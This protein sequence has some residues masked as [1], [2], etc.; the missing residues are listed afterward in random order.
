MTDAPE[1]DSKQDHTSILHRTAVGAGWTIAWRMC[2]R[3]L[4]IVSTLVLVRLLLPA[5]FG[6][7]ALAIGFSQ[8]IDAFSGLGVEEALIREK[9]PSRA[10]YDTGFTI[11]ALRGLL[12][13]AV[14][15]G[16]AWPL[17]WFFAEPRL[18]PVV[19]SLTIVAAANGCEN[20]GIV[21]FRRQMDFRQEFV[22]FVFPRVVSMMAT[23]GAAVALRSYWALIIGIAL[24]AVLRL[25]GGYV[26]HPYRPR[27]SLT[28][29][30]VIAGFSF[31]SWALSVTTL[32]LSR[33][34]NF[35]IGRLLGLTPVGIYA[36]SSEIAALPTTELVAPLGR[37]C[38]SAFA[39]ARNAGSDVAH[40][41][42][43]LIGTAALI[44]LPAG[45]GI[46]LVADPV[47]KLAF[48]DRWQGAVGL[49]EILGATSTVTI[50]GTLS[51]VML[52]AHAALK[53]QFW[54]QVSA[55]LLRI[56]AMA[57][58]AAR[59]GLTGAAIGMSL[60]L[61]I[62]NIWYTA[63]ALRHLRLRPANLLA[64]IW[65][66]VLATLGM[67][68]TLSFLGLGWMKVTGSGVEVV[69][70]LCTTVAAGAAV[71]SA[72]LLLIWLVSGRPAGAERDAL[73]LLRRMLLRRRFDQ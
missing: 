58:F 2:S 10:L 31:W 11:N 47:V 52:T 30:R 61:I 50:F 59:F 72:L 46:S 44:G 21:D 22:M 54:V 73:M 5:D 62:E 67:A 14:I 33:V 64:H 37:A 65:R 63:L 71:Y 1:P 56:A 35:I 42:L 51:T 25:I 9:V 69:W 55:F 40:T 53:P 41:Y 7:V 60:S 19:L 49:I 4:G 57:A 16:G 38:F 27:F 26:L 23:I 39:H 13:V 3:L 24:S 6:L 68:G 66:G 43:R 29:W 15:V 28:E 12:T 17:A 34:D 48:G 70:S 18:V 36:I 45:V 32:L 8:A 20:I